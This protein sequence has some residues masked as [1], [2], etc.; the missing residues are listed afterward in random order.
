MTPSLR[1]ARFERLPKWAQQE[2]ERLER[3]LAYAKE[4]LAE[5]D[6]ESRVFADPYADPP[7]PLG[8]DTAVEFRFGDHWSDKIH[9]R[10]DGDGLKVMGGSRLSITPE[11][12][13]VVRIGTREL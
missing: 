11:A 3:D 7:R 2:I 5:G 10:I 6:S 4:R 8:Y 12:A 13:N 1:D 9:I